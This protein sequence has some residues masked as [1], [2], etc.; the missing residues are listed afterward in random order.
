VLPHAVQLL[1]SDPDAESSHRPADPQ[2]G[3]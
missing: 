2:G 3:Q 1:K